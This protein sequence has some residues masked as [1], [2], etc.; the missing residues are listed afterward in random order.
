MK[1][2]IGFFRTLSLKNDLVFRTLSLKNAAL[3]M[4]AAPGFVS[5]GVLRW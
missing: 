5:E 3:K 2:H 4:R 1:I